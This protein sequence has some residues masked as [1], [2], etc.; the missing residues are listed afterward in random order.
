MCRNVREFAGAC[1][2]SGGSSG[3]ARMRGALGYV[4]V[5]AGMLGGARGCARMCGI[6]GNVSPR[7]RLGDLRRDSW[8]L[9]ARVVLRGGRTTGASTM[10]YA[11]IW[12]NVLDGSGFYGNPRLC[13]GFSAPCSVARGI[14]R[15]W[16]RR[17]DFAGWC[18]VGRIYLFC[19][20]SDAALRGR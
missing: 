15:L 16:R 7:V 5:R 4:W 10:K 11:G 1:A 8:D 12:K 14:C 2:N 13:G 9:R 18:G 3:F 20:I 19:H 17:A 6:R